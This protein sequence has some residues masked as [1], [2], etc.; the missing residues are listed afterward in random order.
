[1]ISRNGKMT[2]L[3]Y[4]RSYS[5]SVSSYP[6]FVYEIYPFDVVL[7]SASISGSHRVEL[8]CAVNSRIDLPHVDIPKLREILFMRLLGGDVRPSDLYNLV[9]WTW[10]FD[11]FTGIGSYISCVETM[12]NDRSLINYGFVSYVSR[13]EIK[14]SLK[15]KADGSKATAIT[16]NPTVTETIKYRPN[17]DASFFWKYHHRRSVSSLDGVRII[18]DPSSLTG[19]QKA[20]VVALTTKYGGRGGG[21]VTGNPSL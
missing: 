3:H 5:E 8:R 7:D 12:L 13:G 21:N 14:S 9:P 17:R 20:I 4:R 10:L 2:T 6:S 18:S 11:W 16:G 19:G 1:L 15:L